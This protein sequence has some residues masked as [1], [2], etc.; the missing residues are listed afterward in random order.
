[1]RTSVGLGWIH[2][3]LDLPPW[4]TDGGAAFWSAALGGTVGAPWP[5]HPAFRSIVP[6]DGQGA[7][8]HLQ[9]GDHGPRVHLDL[10]VDDPAKAEDVLVSMGARR[11][12]VTTAWRVMRSPGGLPFCLLP[13]RPHA[14]VL[15][16][17]FGGHRSRLVQVCIDSPAQL[18]PEEVRF[19]RRFVE[20]DWVASDSVEF[21]GK[22]LPSGGS[23]VQFL[24]QELETGTVMDTTTA[25]VDLGTDDVEAEV[26]RLVNLGADHVA[27]YPGWTVLS[28]PAGMTFCVTENPPSVPPRPDTQS[29]GFANPGS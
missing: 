5:D 20:G 14:A 24:F 6:G 16:S 15:P 23:P 7:Y 8:V 28:D 17:T 21:A 19:W 25:H 3:L 11:C 27:T 10:E 18:H 26:D 4:A 1:M 29:H 13:R 22:I 12:I 2:V 9:T